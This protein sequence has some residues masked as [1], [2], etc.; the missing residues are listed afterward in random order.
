VRKLFRNF[1][2]FCSDKTCFVVVLNTVF[3]IVFSFFFYNI[4][5]NRALSVLIDQVY[6][7]EEL[8]VSSGVESIQVFLEIAGNSLLPLSR[9]PSVIN[10][11]ASIQ[12][13]LDNFI[14]EWTDTPV[15]AVIR[16]DKNGE[17]RFM[18]NNV[19]I[20]QSSELVKGFFIDNRDYFDWAKT[21]TEGDVFLGKPQPARV[22][23]TKMPDFSFFLPL[24]T[25]I[26]QSGEFDG[27]LVLAI[28]LSGLTM[29]YLEPL[30]VSPDYRVYLLH[31]DGTILIGPSEQPG[32]VRL[33]YFEYLQDNPYPGSEKA[34]EDLAKVL[35]A[36]EKG[37]LDA[38]FNSPV[39]KGPTRFL[40]AYSPLFF[41]DDHWTLG[42]AVPF[43]DVQS[44]FNPLRETSIFLLS[45]VVLFTL[46]LSIMSIYFV[47][48]N[49]RKS[50]TQ[51]QEEDEKVEN[52]NIK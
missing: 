34:A 28:S 7:K 45:A 47:K 23:M 49:Y 6:H 15:L 4:A 40:I 44:A 12:E 5:R 51:D 21:A 11:D 13:N 43:D 9:D 26:Y 36:Q 8:A 27:V 3:L 50:Y 37:R 32:L 16:S 29:T 20:G 46:I 2:K 25:P 41:N 17:L 10:Q 48:V 24:V 39:E 18:S 31:S 33:N 42:I 19:D 14:L 1:V 30:E 38:V 35:K 52:G 22:K